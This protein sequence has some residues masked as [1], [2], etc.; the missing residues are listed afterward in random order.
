MTI[1]LKF[2]QSPLAKLSAKPASKLIILPVLNE[3]DLS[4]Q[5][6]SLPKATC[7]FLKTNLDHHKFKAQKKSFLSLTTP[8]SM[9]FARIGL[10]GLK[11]D[12]TQLEA[13][14]L[15]GSLYD[16]IRAPSN[17]NIHIHLDE[18]SK[19]KLRHENA[20]A[21]IAYG[22]LLK[23][24]KF[25]KYLSQKGEKA[26]ARKTIKTIHLFTPNVKETQKIFDDLKQV[27]MGVFEARDLVFEPP[28]ELY[29]EVFAKQCKTLSKL[30]IKVTLLN[31]SKLEKIGMGALLCVSQGSDKD[32]YVVIMEYLGNPKAKKDKPIAFVGKG[33]T[34]D[35]GGISLKPGP[36]MWD[37]KFD[38]GGAAAV[39]GLMRAIAG[40]KAKV[41]AIGIIGLVENMPSGNATRPSDIVKSL[42]GQ[43]IEVLNTDA[44]GR[45]VLADLLTYVQDKYEPHTIIDLA[46][47][48]GAII[49]ALGYEYAGLMSNNDKLSDQL[50]KAG[51]MTGDKVWRMPL[52][53]N[54]DKALDAQIADLQ[55]IPTEKCG[56]GS[57]TAA[58][59]LQRFINKGVAWAHLDIAGMA[60][61]YKPGALGGRGAT[62]YGV[63]LLDEFVRSNYEK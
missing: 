56:G 9:G 28:N 23:S 63:R 2:Y 46:T 40:R 50:L 20:I 8:Q 30:G 48:T 38:M 7:D 39:T 14:E 26:E 58:Q 6:K 3:K 60:W 49:M 27:A 44:E 37:M 33:V 24:Y 19:S 35:T 32:P 55:N 21:H 43:T 41:N 13:E 16:A 22:L 42:S 36:G 1:T 18:L 11:N 5:A 59:F 31:K 34:F 4:K 25:D 10:L 17:E 57:I 29:P 53:K 51:D 45:L 54:F 62:G 52:H 61:L 12:L 47:L 15:G